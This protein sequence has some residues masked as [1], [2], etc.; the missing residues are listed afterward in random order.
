MYLKRLEINGF[1]SFAQKTVLDFLPPKNGRFSITAIVGPN[2]SGKSNVTDAIRWVM[3]ETSMKN[4]RGKKGA[5]VIFSGS[6][7]KGKLGMAETNM[8]LDNSD[9]KIDLDYPEI[10]I[11]RR[12]YR[13]GESEYLINGSQ[14]RLLDIHLLL[15]QAQFAE[16]S[17]SIV[18]QGMIDKLLLVGPKE[19][20]DFLDEASGIKEFQ[21]KQHQ[22]QLKLNR[23]I[24]NVENAERLVVEIEPHLKL[25]SRQVKKLEKRQE[26]EIKLTEAQ[27]SY[28][29]TIYQNHQGEV[30]DLSGKLKTIE[31]EYRVAFTKLEEIQTQLAELARSSSRQ[32]VFVELQKKHQ[33]AVRQKN[34]LERELMVLES[35]MHSE[36]GKEGKG[37]ISWLENKIKDL[38][39]QK[40]DSEHEI[41]KQTSETKQKEDLVLENQ[42]K[43]DEYVTDRTQKQ[44]KIARLQTQMFDSQSERNFLEFSGLTAI[45]AVLKNKN[46]FG[47]IYGIVAELGEV[48]E[49]YRVAL[50]V[51]AGGQLT[52]LVVK[53]ETVARMAIN[54][55]RENRLGVATFLP[56]NKIEARYEDRAIGELLN[57]DGVIGLATDLIKHSSKFDNIFSL[58]LGNTLVVKNLEVAERIGI[59]RARMV[60]LEGDLVEK[61]RIMRGG[62]RRSKLK[63]L[64]FSG[65]MSLTE[66]ERTQEYQA[67]IN[68][69]QQSL[70][71]LETE[72]ENLKMKNLEFKVARESGGAKL[73]ILDDKNLELEKEISGLQR[74]LDLIKNPQ[75]F[76]E[77]L[78]GLEKEKEKINESTLKQIKEVEKLS[79]EIEEFNKKEEEKKQAVFAMQKEMTDL[80]MVV[81]EK[82]QARNELRISLVR[83]ETKQEDL[84]VEVENDMNITINSILE[85]GPVIIELDELESLASKIQKLKYTLSLVGG[86][87]DEVV[88]EYEQTKERYDFLTGQ[89]VDLKKAIEDLNKLI[90]E[91]DTVMKKKRSVAFKKIKKE[92]DRYFKILFDG[93]TAKLEEMYGFEDERES[94]EEEEILKQV[95]D[96]SSEVDDKKEKTKRKKVLTGIDIIANP[97]GKKIKSLNSLSGGERTLTSIALICAILSCNPAPFIVLD[98]V[99]AALDEANSERFAKIMSDLS[100]KSQFIIITHNRVTMHHADALYGVV[101]KGDGVSQLMSVK[102]DN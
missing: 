16:H 94:E 24:D 38:N 6:E 96:D 17:Y 92:F 39:I 88:E 75:E 56:V 101:M 95:Q 59:G 8:I 22:A 57:E 4:I 46:N 20:K 68:L 43:I 84:V 86:I 12:L 18:G 2:G 9:G 19:R 40:E 21:I 52:S 60:T 14:V 10:I 25:L 100:E 41:K 35:Q 98:E 32:D 23:T 26:V 72:I 7:S 11:T 97:P 3:G 33:E 93:G 28:Y 69:E 47:Q 51:A 49:E 82:M 91:L 1:K 90:A 5:D 65:K 29:A 89:L 87:D 99:E 74:E 77:Q 64:G 54:Y 63:G 102:L 34:E 27:E 48:E 66:K 71:E 36:Y 81:N 42:K 53:D 44:V 37:N 79:L 62:F 76:G 85:R 15:A 73:E 50:E 80:Q 67:Q 61:N 31:N 13:S 30:D 55:L 83:I 70:Q 58:A 78:A 45:K